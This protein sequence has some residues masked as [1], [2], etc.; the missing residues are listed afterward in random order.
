ME[1]ASNNDME[2]NGKHA[3]ARDLADPVVNVTLRLAVFWIVLM[4]FYAYNDLMSF[5]RQDIV[6]GVLAGNIEGIEFTQPF[7]FAMALLM[8]FPIF[9]ILL[10]VV[11]PARLNRPV[12]I[13]AGIFHLVLLG[14]T[15]T[16]G[17]EGPWAYYALY[18]AL[19]GI[20]IG[21]ITWTA[22][23]WPASD[24]APHGAPGRTGAE[25]GI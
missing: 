16:V 12:N 5:F 18:M 1:M 17:D 2:M 23:K 14:I 11:L 8:S 3:N 22:W 15:A 13:F 6:E 19:E 4:W 21:L 7:M 25:L 10:S 24:G 9:M 20:I